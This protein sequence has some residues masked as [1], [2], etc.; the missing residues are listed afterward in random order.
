MAA[1]IQQK[2]LDAAFQLNLAAVKK[3]LKAG[4]SIK[5]GDKDGCDALYNAISCL[6]QNDDVQTALKQK[7]LVEFLIKEGADITKRYKF[8]SG[9][10]PLMLAASSGRVAALEAL[11]AAGAD[12]EAADDY[13]YTPLM[14]AAL[15]GHA[16]A[17]RLLLEHGADAAKKVGKED[18]LMLALEG[19]KEE[20]G[21]TGADF[22]TTIELLKKHTPNGKRAAATTTPA[23]KTAKAN[24]LS[25]GKGTSKTLKAMAAKFAPHKVPPLLAELCNYWD[26]HPVFFCGSFEIDEDKYNTVKDWFQG[27]EAGWSKVKL[28][29]VDGIHS[30]YGIW[31]YEGRTSAD[32][33]IVY[34]GGEGEGTTILASTWEEFL[35]ILAANQEW[36]PFDKKFFDATDNNEEQNAAFAAWLKAAHGIAPARNAMA[37]MKKA[38]KEHP[39]L[40]KWLK[41]VIPGWGN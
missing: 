37:I 31:L 28:F 27:N 32:A 23:A 40:G 2:L 18:A 8:V 36:E 29:G 30:L 35:S 15:N 34:L 41:E 6:G 17:V 39:D 20:S 10:T 5:K 22:K 12:V 14:R 7:Q 19:K 9:W 25:E 26:K 3:H 1:G 13:K 4:A 11:I 16:A 38:K 24:V 33:P 21:Q